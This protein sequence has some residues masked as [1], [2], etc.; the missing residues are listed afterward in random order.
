MALLGATA[1]DR[2]TGPAP[3][4]KETAA[5]ANITVAPTLLA[6]VWSK[7]P[8]TFCIWETTLGSKHGPGSFAASGD[9][10]DPVLHF[11]DRVFLAISEE[12][13]PMVTLRADGNGERAVQLESWSTHGTDSASLGMYLTA[14]ARR[15]LGGAKRIELTLDGRTLLDLPMENFPTQAE[16]DNCFQPNAGTGPDSEHEE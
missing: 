4:A 8:E 1:C 9:E 14:E 7:M 10:P 3:P 15:A 2:G 13:R 5:G 11:D 12:D 6:V 16:L